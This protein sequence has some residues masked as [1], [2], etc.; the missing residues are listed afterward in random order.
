MNRFLA[1]AFCLLVVLPRGAEGTAFV[2]E[3][4]TCD[5]PVN[6]YVEDATCGGSS[7]VCYFGDTLYVEGTVGL[8]TDLHSQYMCV[9]TKACFMG[10]NFIC[11]T[12]NKK[13]NVCGDLGLVSMDGTTCPNKAN[14]YF[15]AKV[16]LPGQ[17]DLTLGSGK[18]SRHIQCARSTL[19]S[20]TS[21]GMAASFFPG[22]WMTAYIT[23]SDC[24][25]ESSGFGC[26]ASFS[27]VSTAT[28]NV[29]TGV[30]LFGVGALVFA[31]A[32]KRRVG[33]IDLAREEQLLEGNFEMMADKSVKV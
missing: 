27:A 19:L 28:N 11:K 9:K 14:Y 7:D 16:Q 26:Q 1:I 32:R 15:D 21:H 24:G 18:Y 8:A 12:Y 31:I 17:G 33:T 29:A 10:V 23:V 13:I 4:M 30:V 5:Y 20:S 22:W 2:F 3:E 6:L 25:G